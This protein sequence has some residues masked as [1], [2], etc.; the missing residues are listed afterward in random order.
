MGAVV[1]K[2]LLPSPPRILAIQDNPGTVGFYQ[3]HLKGSLVGLATFWVNE[4][5]FCLMALGCPQ[6]VLEKPLMDSGH[7]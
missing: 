3:G 7:W 6:I 5:L 2:E 4:L 1:L